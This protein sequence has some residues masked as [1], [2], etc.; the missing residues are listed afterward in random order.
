MFGLPATTTAIMIGVL[1]FWVV[2]TVVF[3]ISTSNWSVEDAEDDHE[4]VS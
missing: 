2:Y 4:E 1:G 3:Y